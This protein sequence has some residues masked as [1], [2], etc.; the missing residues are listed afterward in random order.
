MY[1]PCNQDAR[2]QSQIAISAGSPSIRAIQRPL[3][4]YLH[5]SYK[6]AIKR[7]NTY[8]SA[9][10]PLNSKKTI[11]PSRIVLYQYLPWHTL[12]SNRS[13]SNKTI[14]KIRYGILNHKAFRYL[15]DQHFER[16]NNYIFYRCGDPEL[17][18]DINITQDFFMKIWERN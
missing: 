2:F 4:Q 3:T 5:C 12:D 10:A 7:C 6:P 8:C 15:F 17:A 11:F 14:K 16:V 1:G 18:I 13:L 9:S